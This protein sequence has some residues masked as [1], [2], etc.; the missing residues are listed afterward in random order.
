MHRIAQLDLAMHVA[1]AQGH[2]LLPTNPHNTSLDAL[3]A[4]QAHAPTYCVKVAP[5]EW[6][7]PKTHSN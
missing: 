5:I 2:N 1:H 7:K 3:L 6:Q 4:V